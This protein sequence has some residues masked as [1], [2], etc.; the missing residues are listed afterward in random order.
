MCGRYNFIKSP[1]LIEWIR[2]DFGVDL[3]DVSDRY[4]V[5]PSQLM[6][7]IALN[8]SGEPR[9]ALMR[10][11]LVP[12]WEKSAKPKIAPINAR[13]E[14]AMS[15]PMFRQCIQQRRCLI[16]AT[17]FY[18]WKRL[19][20]TVK[21]P[22]AIGL[23]GGEAFCFAGIYESATEQHPETFLL[24]TTSPNKLMTSIH[25]RMPVILDH[26]SAQKWI[27]SG[28]IDNERFGS[29][30]S[31]YDANKMIAWP[32]GTMVG[33]PQNDRPEIMQPTDEGLAN[34]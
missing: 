3:P 26:N 18:E 2:N 6:P 9:A 30:T 17:G 22:Y 32:I 34:M 20:S 21:Q 7:V 33:N 23:R 8:K 11:G 16:P 27:Q 31:P 12:F 19:T 5:A 4:N 15:K 13:S 14:E 29:L 28:G 24:F 25:D 10:W 1:S